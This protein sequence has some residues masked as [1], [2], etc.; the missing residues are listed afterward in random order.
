MQKITP[1]I[2][3]DTQAE[4]AVNFYVSV[5]S[6]KGKNSK[7]LGITHYTEEGAKAS[8]MPAGSI[9]T[10]PFQLDGQQFVALNGGPYLK[11]C[12]AISFVVNCETQDEVDYFWEKL[13]EG[14]E[15]GVC[16][17]INRDKFGVTW[18]VLPAIL[19]QMLQDKDQEKV[20]R[21]GAAVLKMTKLDIEELKRAYRG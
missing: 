8:K 10:I 21:V 19:T 6:A 16:G 4:E 15:K 18:Q 9:M 20:R 5:F 3:F 17:W 12:G 11:L 2:W 13:S 7:I 14:G 1:F